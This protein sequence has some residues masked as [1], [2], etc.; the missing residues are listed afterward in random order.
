MDQKAHALKKLKY[1]RKLQN[2]GLQIAT[3]GNRKLRNL[4]ILLFEGQESMVGRMESHAVFFCRGI[5]NEPPHGTND[6]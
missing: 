3:Q 1:C 2:E 4:T 6:L 5:L